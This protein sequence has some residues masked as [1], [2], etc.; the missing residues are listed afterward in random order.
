MQSSTKL[1]RSFMHD[2][3]WLKKNFQINEIPN[4]KCPTCNSASLILSG[5][6]HHEKSERMQKIPGTYFDETSGDKIPV[7]I[8]EV[9]GLKTRFIGFLKCASA[10][11]NE[12]VTIA[13]Y[14]YTEQVNYYDEENG[15]CLELEDFYYPVTFDPALNYIQNTYLYPMELQTILKTCFRLF[16]IDNSSCANKIRII[17]ERLLDLQKIPKRKKNSKGGFTS[18]TLHSRLRLYK[19]K[20]PK[21]ADLLLSIKWIG[22]AGS[23][24]SEVKT[25]EII[26]A[27]DLLQYCLDHVYLKTEQRLIK[28]SKK[29]NKNKAGL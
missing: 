10:R 21:I 4:W 29:I 16:W 1:K 17:V 18:L 12:F 20:K 7:W 8:D 11:C 22:N 28:I 25:Q 3:I 14:V 13:G 15:E 6:L 26:N 24:S 19:A 27:L 2:R 23:H 5:D 9:E